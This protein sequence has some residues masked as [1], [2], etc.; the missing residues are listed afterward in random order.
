MFLFDQEGE[1]FYE[2]GRRGERSDGMGCDMANCNWEGED[3]QGTMRLTRLKSAFPLL[4][5][6][7]RVRIRHSVDTEHDVD[8]CWA[9]G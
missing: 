8:S 1:T 5:V 6:I 9:V 4:H 2:L 3:M 7:L